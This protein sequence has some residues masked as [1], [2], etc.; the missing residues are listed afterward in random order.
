MN[1][2]QDKQKEKS[3]YDKNIEN[4]SQ[5]ERVKYEQNLIL[6]DDKE[7]LYQYMDG[8]IS[9]IMNTLRNKKELT[10]PVDEKL[11]ERLHGKID[12]AVAL[13]KKNMEKNK[14]YLFS[15]YYTYFVNEALD[16]M[17]K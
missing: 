12:Q 14:I 1:K 9:N 16:E 13:Y 6:S 17:E 4:L 11:R 2:I 3:Q 8:L 7:K 5:D 15:T 10:I